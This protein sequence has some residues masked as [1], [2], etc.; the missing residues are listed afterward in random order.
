MR[1]IVAGVML[2]ASMAAAGTALWIPLRGE[3]VDESDPDTALPG[4]SRSPAA[5]IR[6]G[7]ASSSWAHR[8][9]IL[10][11][12]LLCAAVGWI[13]VGLRPEVWGYGRWCV[14]ALMLLPAM[15]VDHRAHRIPNGI[16]LGGLAGGAVLLGLE[17][18]F[19]RETAGKS[20]VAGL[21]GGAFCLVLLY[22]MARITKEGIGMGDVKLVSA[23]G[24]LLGLSSALITLF[25]ALVL[26]AL[27]AVVLLLSKRRGRNDAIP[28]GPFLYVG[29]IIMMLLFCV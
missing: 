28:F 15:L 7:M 26:C 29:Y 3:K 9:M 1:L 10:I 5:A 25:L 13:A 23:V 6:A 20:L 16:V 4:E 2:L 24:W 19:Q 17:Y 27:T 12:S 14:T 11:S 8:G 18:I 21:V 22:I